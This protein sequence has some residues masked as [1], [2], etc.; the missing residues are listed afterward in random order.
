MKLCI[1]NF[2]PVVSAELDLRKD[3]ILLTRE[4]N[5]GKTYVANV[6]AGLFDFS[7]SSSAFIFENF[8]T[9]NND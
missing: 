5:T 6:V 2:E 9:H 7:T 8:S 1:Q 3:L 4:N